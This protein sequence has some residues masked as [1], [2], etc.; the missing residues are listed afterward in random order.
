MR[1]VGSRL[2][3]KTI[4]FGTSD[5]LNVEQNDA[6]DRFRA[7]IFLIVTRLFF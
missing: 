4:H 7:V 3:V 6:P 5:N 1:G 2:I